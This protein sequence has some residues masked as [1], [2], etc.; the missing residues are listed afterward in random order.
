MPLIECDDVS[1]S[2]DGLRQAVRQLS[3]TVEAGS[4]FALVGP[5]G[6]GKT[7]TLRMLATLTDPTTGKIRIGGLDAARDPEGV[8][9][10]VG[11]L[12]DNFALYDAMTPVD[13][14]DFFARLYDVDAP[15]RRR[16][17]DALLDELDLVDKRA[18]AIRT[19]S[20][21]MRQRLGLA[22]TL[23]HDPQVL[24]LDEPASA[25]DPG[26]RIKLREVLGRLRARG[27]ALIV[28]S[29]IL[30]D[31]AGLADAVGIM[32]SGRLIHAGAIEEIAA[33]TSGGR[34]TYVIELRGGA[35]RAARAL[36]DFGP[37]LCA[38]EELG[39]G[40]FAVELTGGAEAV[41]DLVEALV[42][43]GAR[44]SHVAP[45]ESAIEAVYRRSAAAKVA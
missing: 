26:A 7:S 15:T 25:L 4:L 36:D 42:L 2:Y 41:A 13:Y 5:N 11:Y 1:L 20:R 18:S 12:P 22:K 35:D 27:L 28:S 10:R 21:G 3:F 33:V 6:A 14:L 45:R 17:I 19:L 44:V 8:R 43:R 37:R 32:E 30:P 16:R 40:R 39:P 24:L 34:A 31:L 23:V 38:R 29:H 9:R